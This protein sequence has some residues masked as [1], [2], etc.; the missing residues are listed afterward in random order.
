MEGRGGKI[1]HYFVA[2]SFFS[3][4][5]FQTSHHSL[6]LVFLTFHFLPPYSIAAGEK[7]NGEI[8]AG[9]N[10]FVKRMLYKSVCFLSR[11]A[12]AETPMW[13]WATSS[14]VVV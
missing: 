5:A 12:A 11:Q 8:P 7:K 4:S 13:N 1:F 10:I 3:L 9:K 2:F 6:T 14:S